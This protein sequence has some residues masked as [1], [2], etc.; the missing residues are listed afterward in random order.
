MALTPVIVIGAGGHAK[1]VIELIREVGDYDVVSIVDADPR[2]RHMLGA[3]VVGDDSVLPRLRREGIG[4]VFV[5]VGDNRRRVEI[6]RRVEAQGFRLINAISRRAAVSPSVQLGS[7]V[8]VMAGAVINAETRIGDLVVVNTNAG[9][10][11]DCTLGEGAHIG[12][13]SALAGRVDVGR[14][15]FLGVGTRAIPGVSIGENAVIGAGA[16]V[17]CDIPPNVL[18]Y[19]APAKVIRRLDDWT[20]GR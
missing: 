11:H 10:D 5:A 16:C 13:G 15:A 6:A 9:V 17:V 3:A 18:A 14:L 1:V 20:D 2:P 8:A 12:P 4:H 19:G 7:G